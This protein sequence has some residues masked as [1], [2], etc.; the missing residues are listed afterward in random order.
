MLEVQQKLLTKLLCTSGVQK[1]PNCSGKT[2]CWWAAAKKAPTTKAAPD[3][4]GVPSPSQQQGK[5]RVASPASAVSDAAQPSSLEGVRPGLGA[6]SSDPIE[7]PEPIMGVQS[8]EQV[9]AGRLVDG[10]DTVGRLSCSCWPAPDRQ[11]QQLLTE[12][13]VALHCCLPLVR[14]GHAAREPVPHIKTPASQKV[15]CLNQI[16]ACRLLWTQIWQLRNP[17]HHGG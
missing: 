11:L 12:L 2:A 15:L 6:T 14:V 8:L 10:Q 13:L 7:G 4:A 1:A 5:P 16:T 3:V 17:S 9:E